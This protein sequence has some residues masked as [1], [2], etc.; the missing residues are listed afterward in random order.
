MIEEKTVLSGEVL[1]GRTTKIPEVEEGGEK[2]GN[3]DAL[4][5]KVR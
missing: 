2:V 5:L 4:G 3:R 1:Y